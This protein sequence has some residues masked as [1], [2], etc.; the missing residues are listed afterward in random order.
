MNSN[1]VYNYKVIETKW[2]KFWESKGVYKFNAKSKS[3]PFGVDSPPPTVS[4]KMHIGHAFSYSQQDFIVRYHRMKGEGVFYPFGTDDNGLPTE[5]L[6]ERLKNVKSTKMSRQD[7]VKLCEKTIKEIKDDFINDWKVIGMSCDFSNAYSTIDKHC[8]RTSQ[9]SF[10]DLFKKNLVYQREAPTMW[11]VHCQ[12]AIAQADLED[13]ELDSTFNDVNFKLE[14]D[15]KI[16]IA[17]TRPELLGA[18][19]C[20]YVH[21]DDKRYKRY[22]GKKAIVPLFNYNVPIF[23]DES[24]NPEKGT[25]MLMICS[26]GDKYDVE[27]IKKRKLEPRV[28]FTRDGKLNGLAGKYEGL[29]IKEARKEILNDLEKE[30]LLVSKKPIKHIV[31]VHERCGI[32]V[33]FLSTKQWFIKVLDNKK[34]FV[35]AGRK[36]KWHPE[37]MKLRYEHWIEGLQWDWCISRQRHFGISFP[38]WNCKKCGSVIVAEENNLPVDP[39]V[40]KPKKKCKCSSSSFEGENDVMDTW[41]TSSVTPQIIL[42][43]A[44]DGVYDLEFKKLYPCSLRP[45]AH[46]IIRTWAFYTVVKGIYHNDEVP[47]KNIVISGH[48][49]D[50]KGEAM[51]KSK[52]NVIE[53]AQVLDKFS[54]DA[55]RF[56]AA[57]SKLGDDL[58]YL[59]KDLLTGQRTINKLWNAYKFCKS[60]FGNYKLKKVELEI[61]DQWILHKL[62]NTIKVCTE[63]F[64]SYEY[65]KAKCAIELFFWKDFCDNYLE[66]IKYRLYSE[67]LTKGKESALY[68]LHI[69]FLN[70]IKLFAPIM[71]Y[72]TEEIYQNMFINIENK[73]SVHISNWPVLKFKLDE[74]F[75]EVGD[76]FVRVIG[77]VRQE[78]AKN[79]K[80]LKEPIK[81]LT[82]DNL[83]LN[84]V[85]NDLKAVI[86]AEKIEYGKELKVEF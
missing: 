32:E 37:F 42:N 74:R 2:R 46:D 34:K 56:W 54:A 62:E 12:T 21:P 64:E 33:E 14:D 52:G 78:K 82:V 16:V 10:I 68:T 20:V 67:K 44:K 22:V 79:L 85:E 1:D 26:Y 3:K 15:S 43:W 55:L 63:S 11:C 58:R 50:P 76:E 6:V 36:I 9:K 61:I 84:N 49:L 30:N 25:G 7:F 23:A 80:S 69:C 81:V 13:K 72:V 57:G 60:H 48:V 45:Q 65:S 75:V 86:Q 29:N 5:R 83:I 27:A 35:D 53:P 28:I 18:C 40:D 47:W 24:A 8:R 41:A 51:H 39:L 59:E 73:E 17:T 77:F 4:G 19:V 70:I 71:P 66:F 31:N 38:V